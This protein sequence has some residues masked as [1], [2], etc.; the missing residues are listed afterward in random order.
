MRLSNRPDGKTC[1]AGTHVDENGRSD[2]HKAVCEGVPQDNNIWNEWPAVV[3]FGLVTRCGVAT[4]RTT[5]QV[6][7]FL[8][9]S[10]EL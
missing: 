1:K 3:K 9:I 2:K 8:Q 5:N 6:S 7:F 10:H 4:I